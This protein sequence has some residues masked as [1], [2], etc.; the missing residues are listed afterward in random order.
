MSREQFEDRA[1]ATKVAIGKAHKTAE[2]AIGKLIAT[3]ADQG[4]HIRE[5]GLSASGWAWLAEHTA[6]EEANA[7]A[8]AKDD[9]KRA[10]PKRLNTYQRAL[11]IANKVGESGKKTPELIEEFR[12]TLDDGAEVTLTE[13]AKW[14]IADGNKRDPKAPK[15]PKSW[16]EYLMEDVRRAVNDGASEDEIVG[17][18]MAEIRNNF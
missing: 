12:E 13:F 1:K 9:G 2:T 17:V 8:Q 5:S 11:N 16:Q 6:E 14:C 15:A 7:K 3:Y 18:F 4:E 10:Q